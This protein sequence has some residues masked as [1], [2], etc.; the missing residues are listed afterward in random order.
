MPFTD[1]KPAT[2]RTC[3]KCGGKDV[4]VETWESGDGGHE[5]DLFTCRDCRQTWWVDGIDS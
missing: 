2:D 3:P 1:P 4:T 5:D